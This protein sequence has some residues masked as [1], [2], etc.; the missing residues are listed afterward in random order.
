LKNKLNLDETIERAT[1]NA[2]KIYEKEKIQEQR[3]KVFHNTR[4]LLSHYN[5][6]KAHVDNAIDDI[7]KLEDDLTELGDIERDEMYILSIKRSKSK[8]LIMIA[9]IDMAMELLRRKQVKL[10]YE[11]K[12][13]ALKMFYID[14][15]TY[16]EIQEHFGCSKN[17]PGRWINQ[18]INDLSILLFGIDGVKLDLVQ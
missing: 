4:L 10:C 11:Y 12:Y 15:M 3:K 7:N 8:T 13:E 5:D 9:H 14:E 16:E 6:L 1:Y 2:I 18:M 17:T